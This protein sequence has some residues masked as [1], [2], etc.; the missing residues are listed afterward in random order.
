MRT[1]LRWFRLKKLRQTPATQVEREAVDM[2]VVAVGVEKGTT[3]ELPAQE[4]AVTF[5]DD[6]RIARPEPTILVS[7]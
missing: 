6:K 5:L 7:C 2:N 1:F 3:S 4:G